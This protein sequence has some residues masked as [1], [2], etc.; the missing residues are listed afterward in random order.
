MR[1]KHPLAGCIV[2]LKDGMQHPQFDL[3]G[4]DF[5]LEDYWQNVA[6]MSWQ[7][8]DGNPAA[9]M[10]A[11]RSG[12]LGLPI[13]DEVVYGKVRG[14]GVLVHVSELATQTKSAEETGHDALLAAVQET[15][16]VNPSLR[17]ATDEEMEELV[18]S[19]TEHVEEAEANWVPPTKTD[20]LFALVP[21]VEWRDT[22]E[23]TG[24][25]G[26]PYDISGEEGWKRFAQI[27]A[28]DPYSYAVVDHCNRWGQAMEAAMQSG[29]TV[30][31]CAKRTFSQV[32]EGVTGFMYGAIV[33]SLAAFWQHG[34][35]LRRWH[36]LDTQIGNE[37]ER[38][39]EE[40][41]TLNPAI[42]KT[43]E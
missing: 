27:N 8:A 22:D 11:L 37:G 40:G 28:Q 5:H 42:L 39:N 25:K 38:A 24:E 41:G 34:D 13:D 26:D 7:Q 43:G 36:N 30:E 16:E 19:A 17:M 18:K 10:Y 20:A 14:M 9:I 12:R 21:T 2:P 35:S 31:Q 29:E 4:E 6:G 1:D 33:S 23:E 32:D 15:V 3:D